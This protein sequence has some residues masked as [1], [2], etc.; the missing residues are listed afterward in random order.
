MLLPAAARVAGR[1]E[2]KTIPH[3]LSRKP[4]QAHEVARLVSTLH[5]PR[6]F[7]SRPRLGRAQKNLH[8]SRAALRFLRATGRRICPMGSFA[9]PISVGNDQPLVL[10]LSS[11]PSAF[12]I[13]SGMKRWLLSGMLQSVGLPASSPQGFPMNRRSFLVNSGIVGAGLLGAGSRASAGLRSGIASDFAANLKVEEKFVAFTVPPLPYSSTHSNPT[14]MPRPWKSITT[15]TM[16]PTS[17]T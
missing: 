10:L 11:V 5:R 16:A 3:G 12:A 17:P 1:N 4:S 6:Q 7:R 9:H 15:N 14:S 13:M 2:R 8:S